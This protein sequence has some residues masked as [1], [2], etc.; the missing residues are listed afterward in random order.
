MA[1]LSCTHFSHFHHSALS[2]V[3]GSPLPYDNIL[4]LRDRM[5]EISP[6]L[7]RF[8]VTEST[9][10]EIALSGLKVLADKTTGAKIS[11]AAFRK[12]IT[13][14]Y[15]TDPISRAYVLVIFAFQVIL[16]KPYVFS[17]VTMAQCTRAFVKGE[18]YGFSD[19]GTSSQ[20]QAAFA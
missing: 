20:P 6:T 5:W 3:I 13:N 17:S 19:V 15:Q 4:E 16:T 7:V 14:F 12:P 2:E 11:G 9:S 10:S 1:Y 8:D 18:N